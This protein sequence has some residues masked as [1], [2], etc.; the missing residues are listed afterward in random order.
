M[1][2]RGL[3]LRPWRANPRFRS[4]FLT[5]QEQINPLL[6][7]GCERPR[8]NRRN[9]KYVSS[10]ERDD[11]PGSFPTRWWH[12]RNGISSNDRQKWEFPGSPANAPDLCQWRSY[13]GGYV[14]LTCIGY[15]KALQY[16]NVNSAVCSL[17]E[18]ALMVFAL[19]CASSN[20]CPLTA[21]RPRCSI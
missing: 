12:F 11:V 13:H 4:R 15:W 14:H 21:R 6:G 7:T 2:L 18:Q 1:G 17:D 16:E 3:K 19:L 8:P 20:A 9:S 5:R 10:N